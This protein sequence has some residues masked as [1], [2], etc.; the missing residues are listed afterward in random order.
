MFFSIMYGHNTHK[1]LSNHLAFR[2]RQ[3][4]HADISER[5]HDS[6]HFRSLNSSPLSETRLSRAQKAK[7]TG[8]ERPRLRA[9]AFA[10]NFPFL[11]R[12]SITD[13]V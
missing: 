13:N 3:K 6:F 4:N 5:R 10:P 12:N 11:Q 2:N 1:T 9:S 8:D 7:E